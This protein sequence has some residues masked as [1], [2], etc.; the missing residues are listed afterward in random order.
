MRGTRGDV[1]F[2]NERRDQGTRTKERCR[3]RERKG[4]KEKP[5]SPQ[6]RV[7]KTRLEWRVCAKQRDVD[8]RRNEL[9][10]KSVE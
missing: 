2:S 3:N 6:G 4:A 8:R 10:G 5:A 1:L 7:R 9:R